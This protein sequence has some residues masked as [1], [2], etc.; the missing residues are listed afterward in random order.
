[1]PV[2]QAVAV[3]VALA[4]GGPQ[5]ALREGTVLGARLARPGGD[6]TLAVPDAPAW[7]LDV[8]A[9][10]TSSAG[11]SF[12]GTSSAGTAAAGTL[13]GLALVPLPQ[14]LAP[15]APGQLRIAVRAA[16]LNF[17]DVLLALGMY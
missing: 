9:A 14:A 6:G 13:E 5:G 3:P 8:A 11:T 17:R 12:A 15:L 7:L 10:G 16:G 2:G 1:D 4:A